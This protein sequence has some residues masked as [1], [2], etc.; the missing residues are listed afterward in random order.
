MGSLRFGESERLVDKEKPPSG[1]Y[2]WT[3]V[4]LI[5]GFA[6]VARLSQLSQRRKI[7]ADV[8]GEDA[9]AGIEAE[10]GAA[11]ASG[12]SS[13]RATDGCNVEKITA[14]ASRKFCAGIGALEARRAAAVKRD[15]LD[16]EIG[17]LNGKEPSGPVPSSDDPQ[18]ESL[19]EFLQTVG[20]QVSLK[21]IAAALSWG[22]G[23]GVEVMAATFPAGIL[24]ILSKIGRPKA[25]LPLKKE[26]QARRWWY[27][28]KKAGEIETAS[29]EVPVAAT[30]G[31]V[32]IGAFYARRVEAATGKYVASSK[33]FEAW[34]AHCE[35]RGIEPGS[36]KAFSLR[37]QKIVSYERNNGR[38]GTA[39]FA[40]R[41][42]RRRAL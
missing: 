24:S 39:T 38:R 20:Y 40:S 15:E 7:V 4:F 12:A 25:P 35:G 8:A 37:I 16:K 32:E 31:D 1:L 30:E 27:R 3:A 19:S 18:A 23:I 33:L 5:L 36:A 14:G 29:V 13:W 21:R 22:T 34:K 26:A 17:A 28:R 41:M 6:I 9:V 10:I 11:K 42:P 2:P